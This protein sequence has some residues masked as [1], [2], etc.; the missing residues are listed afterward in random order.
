MSPLSG[1]AG[2][3]AAEQRRL[4]HAVAAASDAALARVVA[5]FDRLADRREADRV[6]DA[7]R[8]RLRRLRPPRPIALPRLLFLPLDG[9]IADARSWKRQDGT[10]PRSALMPLSEAV[11]EAIGDVAEDIEA[12]IAGH[13]FANLPVV[14]A[15]GLRLWRAA[16]EATLAPPPSWAGT[17]LAATDFRHCVDL[18]TG[19][20]RHATP[21]WT[22]LVAA[23]E[24][25]P[26]TLV[27]AALADAANEPPMVV[28]A[29]LATLLM[30]AAKPGSVAAAAAA[31]KVGTAGMAEKMLD[32]WIEDCQPDIT[33]AD[34]RG[35]ARIA[36]EFAEAIA[37]LD[38]SP[39][40]RQPERRQRIAALRQQADEACRVA[41]TE[42]TKQALLVPLSNPG[43]PLD[44]TAIQ[45]LEAAARSLKR[46]E[47]AG[48]CLGS[49]TAYDAAVRRITE[50]FR[51]LRAA[52][53]ANIADLAR[54]TEIIAGPEAAM[55]LFEG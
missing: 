45:A 14:A 13:S 37:D 17:G 54:L 33:A 41:F 19:V 27:K 30:K 40:A 4:S 3:L 29:M 8:P 2:T 47:Q 16:A 15:A 53:G 39:A 5:V 12:R 9:A 34:P 25:P 49:G 43:Q 48:R 51:V 18:A 1:Q 22:A 26:E 44:D 31:A 24:G 55:R 35:A 6:L 21:L 23:R 42:A 32:R 20:W 28:E 52:P 50:A 38:T 36:E 46:L 11:R 7:A 10:L